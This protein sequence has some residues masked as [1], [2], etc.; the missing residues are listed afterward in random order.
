MCF[1]FFSQIGLLTFIW[2]EEVDHP[3]DKDDEE[4]NSSLII[5]RFFLSIQLVM[6]LI[7]YSVLSGAYRSRFK[8]DLERALTVELE[9]LS[10]VNNQRGEGDAAA[11]YLNNDDSELPMTEAEVIWF[12]KRTKVFSKEEY[13]TG[14]VQA[15]T[16]PS[17]NPLSSAE[18]LA[19]KD[20]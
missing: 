11:W 20:D 14:D 17:S 8:I 7:Y 1:T 18:K 12:S 2:L 6:N 16:D 4:H 19:P 5:Q 10:A 13:Q 15:S 3:E 9:A